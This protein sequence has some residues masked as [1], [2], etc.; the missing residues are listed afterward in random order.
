MSPPP[1]LAKKENKGR[2]PDEQTVPDRSV[3]NNDNTSG[4]NT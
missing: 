1:L 4:R 2:I 3:G